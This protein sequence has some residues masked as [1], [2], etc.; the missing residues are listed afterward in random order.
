MCFCEHVCAPSKSPAPHNRKR[1][2]E[3][4]VYGLIWPQRSLL[5]WKRAAALQAFFYVGLEWKALTLAQGQENMTLA[6][7]LNNAGLP[8]HISLSGIGRICSW[9]SLL[10]NSTTCI[11]W[12][13][14]LRKHLQSCQGM[15]VAYFF[16][17]CIFSSIL[18]L[19]CFNIHLV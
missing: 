13:C 4:R 7:A 11:G 19:L 10:T 5:F 6:E 12:K 3:A 17:L 16:I 2:G 14:S 15:K 9:A 8:V 18:P 1:R